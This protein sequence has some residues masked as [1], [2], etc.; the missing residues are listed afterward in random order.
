MV[1]QYKKY[2]TYEDIMDD[3]QAQNEIRQTHRK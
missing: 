3:E 1:A 2:T